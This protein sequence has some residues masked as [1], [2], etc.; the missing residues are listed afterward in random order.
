MTRQTGVFSFADNFECSLSAPLDAR[1]TTPLKSQLT[2]FTGMYLGMLVVVTS[3]TTT[4]NNGLYR[5]KENDGTTI[6]DWEQIGTG[7]TGSISVATSTDLGGIKIGY[8]KSGTNYP[9]ELDNEKA[10][11]NVSDIPSGNQLVPTITTDGYYLKSN[12]TAG[13]DSLSW[14]ALP[15]NIPDFNTAI[16]SALNG[17][18]LMVSNSTGS[19]KLHYV[20]LPSYVPQFE[21]SITNSGVSVGQFLKVSEDSNNNRFVAYESV[22]IPAGNQLVPSITNNGYFLRSDDD[23]IN[24]TLTWAEIDTST[25]TD[26]STNYYAYKTS[27]DSVVS[28]NTSSISTNASTLSDLS[29]NYYAYKTSNDSAVSTNTSNISTNASTL[30]DLSTNFYTTNTPGYI[31]ATSTDTLTNKSIS[32]SQLTGTPSIPDVSDFITANSTDILTNKSI[33]YSQLTGT[34]TIP[35]VPENVPLFHSSIQGATDGQF[36]KVAT[37]SGNKGVKYESVTIPSGN[38]LV[39]TITND[40]YFLRSDDDGIIQTLT[41]VEAPTPPLASPFSRGGVKIGYTQ[42]AKNYPLQLSAEKA[43]V[44]VPWTD[45]TYTLPTATTSTLGGI[46]IGTGLSMSS[47]VCSVDLSQYTVS[48]SIKLDTTGNSCSITTGDAGLRGIGRMLI[49]T[50]YTTDTASTDYAAASLLIVPNSGSGRDSRLAIRGHRNAATDQNQAQ[51]MFENFD[52]NIGTS[53]QSQQIGRLG[54]ISG[55]VTNATTNVGGLYFYSSSNGIALTECFNISPTN[56]L[57]VGGNLAISASSTISGIEIKEEDLATSTDPF[58]LSTSTNINVASVTFNWNDTNNTGSTTYSA[59]IT[60]T[61]GQPSFTVNITGTYVISV[62]IFCFLG[63]SNNR[64]NYYLKLNR[65]TSAGVFKNR[66]FISGSNYYRDD[67]D[68]FDDVALTGTITI[69]LTAGE[70][71]EIVC[72]ALYRENTGAVTASTGSSISIER[73]STTVVGGGN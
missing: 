29:T 8:T 57:N 48:N 12:I 7:G 30:S 22:T 41:W 61:N 26:L 39:P 28:T 3:D 70:N 35:F 46:I 6:T 13:T 66:Y 19:N 71:F 44:N 73:L 14:V 59:G 38:Q 69:G 36:L 37:E 51:L 25:L 1:M 68:N 20:S 34:P 24:Q 10:Y 67:N 50:D 16:S 33:S 56:T 60:H 31:T 18:F 53:V 5:L 21:E 65:R 4:S 17:Q 47:S 64:S 15:S 32:Y 55:R 49:I 42:N 58:Y 72:T 11:V 62:G 45:T 40:G 27:N 43:F 9:L 23:G 2:G 54:L 52:D 63:A